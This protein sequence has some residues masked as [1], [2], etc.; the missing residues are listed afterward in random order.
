MHPEQTVSVSS[1]STQKTEMQA[2]AQVDRSKEA[3]IY[4]LDALVVVQY[5]KGSVV[6]VNTGSTGVTADL[7]KVGKGEKETFEGYSFKIWN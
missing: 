2:M 4:A 3:K 1:E 5:G 6:A 7:S